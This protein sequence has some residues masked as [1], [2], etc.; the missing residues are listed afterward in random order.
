[1][2]ESTLNRTSFIRNWWW[3]RR[4]KYNLG[5][6]IAG[7]VAFLLYNILGPIFI[8]PHAVE[9]EDTIFEMAFQGMFY[10]IMMLIANAFYT[11]GSLID[12]SINTGNSNRFRERLFALGYWFS[13][14]LPSLVI[15]G[16]MLKFMLMAPGEM[17]Q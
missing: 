5:L 12:L 3:T 16:I 8:A 13:V 10:L 9:F 15:L 6:L 2:T 17:E 11:F 14:A 1:M 4:G 7:F